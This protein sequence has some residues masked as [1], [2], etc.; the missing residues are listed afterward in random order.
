MSD[1]IQ[2]HKKQYS[3]MRILTRIVF[4]LMFFPSVV[5]AQFFLDVRDIDGKE[6]PSAGF[7]YKFSSA[8]V[9]QA[10]LNVLVDFDVK[11][12][13]S[14][15]SP[16][17]EYFLFSG[18]MFDLVLMK[19]LDCY[20]WFEDVG[21]EKSILHGVGFKRGTREIASVLKYAI[22]QNTI[23]KV[24][25]AIEVECFDI[26]YQLFL[27]EQYQKILDL[28][29]EIQCLYDELQRLEQ[30]TPTDTPQIQKAKSTIRSKE[31]QLKR[32]NSILEQLKKE[33]ERNL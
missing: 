7:L 24:F 15:F 6:I 23:K 3:P 25:N 31:N 22:V 27:A 28:D 13:T 33:V 29:K 30:D 20:I 9:K 4:F 12:H 18:D 32:E 16:S 14:G 26:S 1:A 8:I 11:R 5:H 2:V 19:G 10:T 21:D 17:R